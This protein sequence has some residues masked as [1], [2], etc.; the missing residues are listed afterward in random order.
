MELTSE[1]CWA[2]LDAGRVG[3]VVFVDARGP[4]ALPVNYRVFDGDIVF[5]TAPQSSLL[6]S[7]SAGRVSFQID[8]IDDRHR[9][10]WS[11]LATGRVERA[12]GATELRALQE[13][14]VDPWAEEGRTQYLRLIV[15][16]LTGRRIAAVDA[17]TR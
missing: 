6:A 13:L 9:V 12:T 7:S 17:G 2:R 1:E 4:V 3:R 8:D 15:G 16:H 5:R 14:G 11:V 10:G